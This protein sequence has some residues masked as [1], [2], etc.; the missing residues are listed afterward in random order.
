[1]MILSYGKHE[2]ITTSRCMCV[3]VVMISILFEHEGMHVLS[4]S[5]YLFKVY[6]RALNAAFTLSSTF[7]SD[8]PD[9]ERAA[10]PPS[11]P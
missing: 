7:F 4:V 9:S 1:M 6:N 11:W 8:T 5:V 3:M 2:E 10:S